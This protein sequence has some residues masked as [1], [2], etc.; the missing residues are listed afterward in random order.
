MR[1]TAKQQKPRQNNVFFARYFV[2]PKESM[3]QPRGKISANGAGLAHYEM[4]A[5]P[6]SKSDE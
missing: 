5:P 4:G 3:S 2:L 6:S 1:V